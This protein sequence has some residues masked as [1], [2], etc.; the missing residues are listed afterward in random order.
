MD[1]ELEHEVSGQRLRVA[2]LTEA[3]MAEATAPPPVTFQLVS[4][5]SWTTVPSGND[6]I[7]DQRVTDERVQRAVAHQR[8]AD[9]R[10]TDQWVQRV[11]RYQRIG[12]IEIA[13]QRVRHEWGGV[14]VNS[15]AL[16]PSVGFVG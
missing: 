13:D 6:R 9:E 12:W 15:F 5:M 1:D 10:I 3:V 2:R 11:V 4:M 16:P 7:A 14:P 8:V